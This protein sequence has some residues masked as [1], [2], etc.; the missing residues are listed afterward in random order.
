MG[1]RRSTRLGCSVRIRDAGPRR[2]TI[3]GRE[4]VKR[5]NPEPESHRTLGRYGRQDGEIAVVSRVEVAQREVAH[6][7]PAVRAGGILSCCLDAPSSVTSHL[8]RRS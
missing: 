1:T 8:T 4:N 7:T 6:V 2:M 3:A 5:T